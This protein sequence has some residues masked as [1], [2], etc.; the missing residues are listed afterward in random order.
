M[1]A[2][3][4]YLPSYYKPSL[5]VWSFYMR[6]ISAVTNAENCE[7]TTTEDH[8]Y[9]VGQLVRVHIEDA[10]GMRVNGAAT[11]ILS[12]PSSTVFVCDL[13]TSSLAAFIS[14]TAPPPFTPAHVVPIT[15]TE[16]NIA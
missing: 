13:N 4:I 6:E 2:A 15:G 10:Y 11:Q 8:G 12:L 14:P 9:E 16:E 3:R 1:G 7:I 5:A